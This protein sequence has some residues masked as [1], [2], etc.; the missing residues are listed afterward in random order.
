MKAHIQSLRSLLEIKDFRAFPK[1]FHNCPKVISLKFST[2]QS[3][4]FECIK[5]QKRDLNTVIKSDSQ[6]SQST[7][8]A[9]LV[10]TIT[11]IL[12]KF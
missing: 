9:V 11:S 7:A 6:H 4:T 2:I 5:Q 3:F 1:I 8:G 10:R 12:L